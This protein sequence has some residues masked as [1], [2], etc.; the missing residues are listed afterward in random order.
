[1]VVSSTLETSC[2]NH[3]AKT[4][5]TKPVTAKPEKSDAKAAVKAVETKSDQKPLVA[6]APPVAKAP[7]AAKAPATEKAKAPAA[8]P[9]AAP[10][11]AAA[12]PTGDAKPA[13]APK[14]TADAKPAATK[15]AKPAAKAD[16]KA[17]V[18][19]KAKPA[20][21]P[22]A[23]D[24]DDA[25]EGPA[26]AAPSPAATPGT[27]EPMSIKDVV[28]NLVKTSKGK[29][30]VTY[31]Q[32]NALL[33]DAMNDPEL[34]DQI[35]E[36][37]ES[38]GVELV[39]DS[40]AD[41][42]EEE[43][44]EGTGG[45]GEAE[46]GTSRFERLA[47][48]GEGEDVEPGE[49]NDDPVRLYLSQMGEIPLLTR[50][51]EIEYARSIEI[52]REGFRRKAMTTIM[53]IK[54]G[55]QWVEEQKEIKEQQEKNAK[56]HGSSP[57]RD[58]FLDRAA[59]HLSTLAKLVAHVTPMSAQIVINSFENDDL[60]AADERLLRNRLTRAYRL[61]EEMELDAKTVI[62]TKDEMLDLRR[63]VLRIRREVEQNRKNKPKVAKEKEAELQKIADLVGEHIDGFLDRCMG[64]SRRF[65][66]YEDAKQKLSCGNLRLVVSIAKKYRNRGLSFL[67]LI[68]EGNTGL[69]KGVE[70]YEYKRGYKF[71]TYATWWIRQ[72]IT[73]AIADQARTIRI[74][75]H[76][77]ETMGKLRKIQKDILQ[78]TGR[79]GTIE[80]VAE[81]A[82]ISVQE[83]K[84][85]IHAC[86]HPISLDRPIGDSDDCNFGDFLE[87]KSTQNPANISS[88]ELLKE[89][90]TEVL[91][92]LSDREREIICLRFGIVDGYTYTLEEVGRRFNVTRER[93][94]QIEAKSIKKLQ[95]PT[96]ARKLEGF[97]DNKLT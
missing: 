81:R 21:A 92:T 30:S 61:L 26:A 89:K 74:P 59:T 43:A 58:V 82:G 46:A 15:V 20:A 64:V 85:V 66:A 33:P 32:L 34:L 24:A 51:Q 78:D 77:I 47:P 45:D 97:I 6:K 7:A 60:R 49:K 83:C 86:K 88:N 62:Q 67:D 11:P 8:A 19:A 57:S 73:R 91:D 65:R 48:T 4:S 27:G 1:M 16:A 29:G 17:K 52:F 50:D 39:E 36:Q 54:A 56:S 25:A 3:M 63:K 13:A 84:R 75:V 12:K 18:D 93:I 69:M 80:E 31:D 9:K 71:S 22:A 70:K 44:E 87:D 72:G 96:R 40:G 42:V 90:I 10:K 28:A 94:R 2:E 76:M 35:L 38:R 55:I 37:L 14:P 23:G 5:S 68:Q 79:E 41:D 53:G 95:H